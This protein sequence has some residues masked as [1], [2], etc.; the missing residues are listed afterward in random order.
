M[1]NPPGAPP[2]DVLAKAAGL[3]S[4]NFVMNP[5]LTFGMLSG[6]P[7]GWRWIAGVLSLVAL[8]ILSVIAGRL[9]PTGGV[10]TVLSRG[11]VFGGAAGNLVDRVRFGAVVDFLDFYWRGYHWPA[12]NVA[13]SAIMVGGGLLALRMTL[14]PPPTGRPAEPLRGDWPRRATQPSRGPASGPPGPSQPA[15]APRPPEPLRAGGCPIAAR[16]L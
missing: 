13:D 6:T 8:A 14:T 11:L 7:G 16:R 10:W 15:R 1:S 2:P 3:V 4:L 12:F 9:L 5:E